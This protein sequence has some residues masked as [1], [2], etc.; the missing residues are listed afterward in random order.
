MSS[1]DET[2]STSGIVTLVV[3]VVIGPVIYASN[4]G[5]HKLV[6]NSQQKQNHHHQQQQQEEDSTK[7]HEEEGTTNNDETNK[8]NHATDSSAV[9]SSVEDEEGED[10]NQNDRTSSS[11]D[12][13]ILKTKDYLFALIGYSIGIGNVWRFPYVIA[14]NGGGAALIAYVVCAVLFSG[15]VYFWESIVGQ[16][17]RLSS[18]RALQM[19]RPRWQGLGWSIVLMVVALTSYYSVI[20]AWVLIYLWNSLKDP[21]PWLVGDGAESFFT[22]TVLNVWENGPHDK[23]SGPG[24]ISPSQAGALAIYYVITFLF[25]AF[26]RDILSRVTYVTVIMPVVLMAIMV[27]RTAFLQG[28]SDG[29]EFYIGRFEPEYLWNVQTWVA[30]CTQTLFSL[31]VGYGTTLTFGSQSQPKEDMYR[32]TVIISTANATFSI[33]S[34]FAVFAMV[35][36]IAYN[37]DRTVEDVATSSGFGLAFVT[38]ASAMQ[39]FGSFANV[40]SVIFFVMLYTLAV[41]SNNAIIEVFIAIIN[42]ELDKRGMKP[43]GM[44]KLCLII[45]PVLFLLGL[46]YTTRSGLYILDIVDHFAVTLLLLFVIFCEVIAINFD[47]GWDRI[48][49]QLK[50][51]TYG[52]KRTPHGRQPLSK[53]L[54]LFDL[55]FVAIVA[56]GALFL[57]TFINDIRTPYGDYPPSLLGWGWAI[58]GTAMIIILSTVWKQ[59][60]S[61]LPDFSMDSIEKEHDD[62]IDQQRV[63][64]LESGS[65][66]NTVVPESA[67]K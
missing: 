37:E 63:D 21:L 62:S 45:F 43:V 10:N 57:K 2:Y 32:T 31:G 64:A 29:I 27:F 61:T 46:P 44:K 17:T 35:G 65:I 53:W 52:N 48:M 15:P 6:V 38:L 9:D 30:A 50:S 26:G 20:V 22:D 55:R 11:Q 39:Y 12:R 36:V 14:N 33:F 19:I 18:A 34:G 23:P 66:F 67:K 5:Y 40:F 47:F 1:D 7:K 13:E 56:P 51:A 54:C 28:A 3:L 4:Y 16:H 24:P 49:Y 58:L 59:A 8:T 60:P 42:D 25:F 41:D